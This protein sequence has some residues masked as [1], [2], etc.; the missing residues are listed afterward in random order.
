MS[1]GRLPATAKFTLTSIVRISSHEPPVPPVGPSV[2]I[3]KTPE[4]RAARA[5]PAIHGIPRRAR[6]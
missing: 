2:T 3:L 6:F 5:E 4:F 1:G